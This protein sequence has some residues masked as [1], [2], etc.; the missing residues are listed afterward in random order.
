MQEYPR[1]YNSPRSRKIQSCMLRRHCWPLRD[2]VA[3][4]I[5]DWKMSYFISGN[6]LAFC[7]R[8]SY[9]TPTDHRSLWQPGSGVARVS[10]TRCGVFRVS[11]SPKNSR[12]F[13]GL[14][15]S[16]KEHLLWGVSITFSRK[17]HDLF[18]LGGEGFGYPKVAFIGC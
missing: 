14:W 5:A 2:L 11:P 9:A 7:M 17:T 8:H 3:G 1:E 4:E 15:D 12:P 16:L 13:L 18:F 6:V 10:L